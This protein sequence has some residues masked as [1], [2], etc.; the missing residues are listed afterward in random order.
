M[1]TEL[2]EVPRQERRQSHRTWRRHIQMWVSYWIA[3]ILDTI[4]KYYTTFKLSDLTKEGG[5]FKSHCF[6]GDHVYALISGR[7]CVDWTKESGHLVLLSNEKWTICCCMM[8]TD[9]VGYA[10]FF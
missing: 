8:A 3:F 1:C 6:E 2:E 5:H 9:W 10:D 4:E 7:S